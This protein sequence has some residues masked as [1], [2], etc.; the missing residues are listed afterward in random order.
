MERISHQLEIF[1]QITKHLTEIVLLADL[2]PNL[3][4]ILVTM[5]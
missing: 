1:S 4:I 5:F 2:N 3:T